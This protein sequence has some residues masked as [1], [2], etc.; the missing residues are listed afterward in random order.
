M[1]EYLCFSAKFH[2]GSE[3]VCVVEKGPEGGPTTRFCLQR[4]NSS[5]QF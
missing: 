4:K 3:C 1:G 5:G 2:S